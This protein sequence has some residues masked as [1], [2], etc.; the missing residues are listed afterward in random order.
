[1]RRR[2]FE[3][4]LGD[5]RDVTVFCVLGVG[6]WFT[7]RALA[8]FGRST[9]AVTLPASSPM[10]PSPTLD[11]RSGAGPAAR[12]SPAHRRNALI[13]VAAVALLAGVVAGAGGDDQTTGRA[14]AERPPAPQL[15]GG[16]RRIIPGRHVVALYGAPQDA[17][18]GA[19][20]IGSPDAAARRLQR[21]TRAYRARETRSSRPWS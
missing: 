15:P 16:G 12:R 18:L 10:S 13:A 14:V 6:R 8:A 3:L 17:E 21:Q 11:V 19:L 1:M 2:Y 9:Q 20:G 7:Q 4:V 5:G